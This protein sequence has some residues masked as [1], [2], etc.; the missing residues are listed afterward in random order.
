MSFWAGIRIDLS[1][2]GLRLSV[3]VPGDRASIDMEGK[4]SFHGSMGPLRY[5]KTATI[6]FDYYARGGRPTRVDRL[7]GPIEPSYI[8]VHLTPP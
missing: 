5:Q 1:K 4:A 7:A 8:V 6:G 2:S 3:G